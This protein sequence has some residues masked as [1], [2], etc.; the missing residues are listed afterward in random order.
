MNGM[1]DLF[2]IYPN[3]IESRLDISKQKTA[4]DAYTTYAGTYE[5]PVLSEHKRSAV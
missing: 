3:T 2:G 5:P 1:S 4:S